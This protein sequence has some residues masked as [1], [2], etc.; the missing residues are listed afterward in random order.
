MALE[1]ELISEELT[2]YD[3]VANEIEV[4]GVLYRAALPSPEVYLSA[5][6]PVKVSRHLYRPAGRSSKSICPSRCERE[7]SPVTS[8]PT[9]LKSRL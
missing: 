3:V 2:C 6:R 1:C 9:R 5:A 7:L 4:G 8:R